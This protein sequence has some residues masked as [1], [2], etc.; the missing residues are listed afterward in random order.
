M[1]ESP[2]YNYE[3]YVA[4]VKFHQLKEIIGELEVGN[5]L[6]LQPEPT[7]KFDPNA[8][9]ILYDYEE[10]PFML[11]YVPA[12]IS[13]SV[14]ASFEVGSCECIITELNPAEKPWLQLKVGI[15]SI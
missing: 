8:V 7:N 2:T 11:G 14:S 9:K 5:E 15:R 12:K 13:A 4:G 6:I 1:T 3:F 10:T